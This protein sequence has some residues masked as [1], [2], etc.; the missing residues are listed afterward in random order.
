MSDCDDVETTH[1]HVCS[2]YVVSGRMISMTSIDRCTQ[3]ESEALG[4]A[5]RAY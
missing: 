1:T 5:A 2:L 3:L 4:F